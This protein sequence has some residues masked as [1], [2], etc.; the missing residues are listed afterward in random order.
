MLKINSSPKYNCQISFKG[1]FAKTREL[2]SAK[3]NAKKD[4]VIEF[5]QLVNKMGKIN[6]N[7][8][9]KL[10]QLKMTSI[11]EINNYLVLYCRDMN[12]YK[13]T[14]NL[15]SHKVNPIEEKNTSNKNIYEGALKI[16]NKI[17]SKQI[18]S[19]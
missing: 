13:L 8:V 16:I 6:D 10:T 12:N 5:E 11:S 17:I 9:C 7:K 15:I 4:D 18:K 2:E 1:S 19:R 3:N 14:Q